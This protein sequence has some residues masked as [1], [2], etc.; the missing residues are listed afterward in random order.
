MFYLDIAYLYYNGPIKII[1]CP[2]SKTSSTENLKPLYTK[3]KYTQQIIFI[4]IKD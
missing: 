1:L 4:K 2:L 3:K